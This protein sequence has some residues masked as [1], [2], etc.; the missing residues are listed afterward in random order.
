LKLAYLRLDTEKA[1]ARAGARAGTHS[2]Q[3]LN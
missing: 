2:C 3:A 1:C